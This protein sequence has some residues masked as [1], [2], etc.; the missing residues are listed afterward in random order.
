MTIAIS[1]LTTLDQ[2]QF[3]KATTA[4]EERVLWDII[5]GC[6]ATL[7]ACTWVSVHPNMTAQKDRTVRVMLV[8]LELMIWS[9]LVPEMV[10]F[11]ALRQWIGAYALSKLHKGLQIIS[12]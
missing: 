9:L 5:K 2:L 3:T 12:A 10:I 1:N 6:T 8:R 4:F 7:I 11:W